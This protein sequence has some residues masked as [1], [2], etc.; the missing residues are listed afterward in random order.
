TTPQGQG[1][2]HAILMSGSI[3]SHPARYAI[4][5]H[6][7]APDALNPRSPLIATSGWLR[8]QILPPRPRHGVP[9]AGDAFSLASA[10][11]V[12]AAGGHQHDLHARSAWLRWRSRCCRWRIRAE[13]E[14]HLSVVG[15]YASRKNVILSILCMHFALARNSCISKTQVD[16][17]PR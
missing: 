4:T 11:R 13:T 1:L 8:G 16:V 9:R 17:H 15:S 6:F 2:R 5:A 3:A 14:K 10:A 7:P 12:R